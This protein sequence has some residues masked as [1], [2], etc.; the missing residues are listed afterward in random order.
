LRETFATPA[1]LL[2]GAEEVGDRLAVLPA[3]FHLMWRQELVADL[4]GV[5]LSPATLVQAA[6]VTGVCR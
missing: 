5:R 1:P 6:G 4:G 3:L 2:A